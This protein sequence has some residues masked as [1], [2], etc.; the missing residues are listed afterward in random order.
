MLL[1][2]FK[3]IIRF[4]RVFVYVYVCIFVCVCVCV[5]VRERE[6]ERGGERDVH[7][8]RVYVYLSYDAHFLAIRLGL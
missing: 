1:V 7:E 4:L 2:F 3:K 5:C 8:I 6:R